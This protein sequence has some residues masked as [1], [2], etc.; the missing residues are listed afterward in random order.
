MKRTPLERRTPLARTSGLR[1][2]ST[3]LK[4]SPLGR[5]TPAQRERVRDLACIVCANGAG[6]CHPAHVVDRHLVTED[7]ANDV[8]AVVPLCPVCHRLYDD[9]GLDLSPYLEPRWRD[10]LGWAVESAGL[11]TALRRITGTRWQPL[12]ESEAA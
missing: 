10:S 9:A 3:R 6:H 11:F 4:R 7:A 5:A 12:S 1:R 2:G 8:R